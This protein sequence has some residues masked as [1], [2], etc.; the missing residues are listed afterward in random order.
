MKRRIK[1]TI[2]KTV[3]AIMAVLFIV[4]ATALDSPSR[5]P[6]V[7]CSIAEAWLLLFMYANRK[8]KWVVES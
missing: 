4:S 7:V 8:A 3:T 1:N 2:L 5:I 6:L